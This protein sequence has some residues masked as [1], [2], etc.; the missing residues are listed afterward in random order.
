MTWSSGWF[1]AAGSPVSIRIDL[2]PVDQALGPQ[3]AD[4]ELVLGP[5]RPHRDRD[6]DRLLAGTRGADLE[7]LLADDAVGAELE[8]RA[9]HGDDPGRRDVAG[10][11][12]GGISRSRV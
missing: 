4:R 3:E 10:R 6:R 12:G 9:A 2:G 11:R 5:G 7:R 8:R 1:I